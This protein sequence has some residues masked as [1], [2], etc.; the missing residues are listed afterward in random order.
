MTADRTAAPGAD[1]LRI[2]DDHP[3]FA[4]HFPGQPLL[5]GALLLAE[6]LALAR[7]DPARAALLGPQPAISQAKFLA[8]VPPGSV[9][10]IAWTPRHGALAFEVR[11]GDQPVARGQFGARP[12]SPVS[13]T[14]TSPPSPRSA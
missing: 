7:R 10:Q 6:L 4:G 8:P 14:P 1:T 11:R 3:S 12:A 5:P 2:P 13:P 9:L